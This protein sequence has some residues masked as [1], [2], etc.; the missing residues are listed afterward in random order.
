[1]IKNPK[2]KC[3]ICS[4]IIPPSIVGKLCK[5]CS[6]L[7]KR[8]YE[9]EIDHLIYQEYLTKQNNSCAICQKPF[10]KTP[11]IDHDHKTGRVRGL[12]CATCNHGI[13]SLKDSIIL[14]KRAAIYLSGE[15]S[16]YDSKQKDLEDYYLNWPNPYSRSGN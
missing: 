10:R 15:L 8:C 3:K 16:Q 11:H 13:G 6:C 5:K 12:L 4:K 7:L 14:L 2:R 1:M 9:Y